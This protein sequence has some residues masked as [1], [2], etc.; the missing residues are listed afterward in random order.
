MPKLDVYANTQ[1]RVRKYS[2]EYFALAFT[3]LLGGCGQS[4]DSS[5]RT[6]QGEKKPPQPAAETVTIQRRGQSDPPPVDPVKLQEDALDAL[7]SGDLDTAFK[8]VRAAKSA[9]PDD[10]QTIFL[11]ARV[12]AERNRF[13]EAIKMLD[14]LAE[15]VPEARLPVLGQ[16]ADWSVFQGQWQ[17]AEERYRALLDQVDDASM[18]HRKLSQL[19]MREGRRL[20]ATAYLRELCRAGD[21]EELELRSLLITVHPFSGE[22]ATDELEPIGDMGH[23]RYEISQGNWDAALEVLDRSKS[24]GPAETALRGRIL[25]HLQDFESLERWVSDAPEAAQ[26]TADYWF[27]KGLYE[28]HRGDHQGGGGVFL[29]GGAS[30]SN[31]R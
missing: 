8:L 19:L 11:M 5:S 1:V 26:E 23:A 9:T 20:E 13:P 30:R 18:V 6:S 16:T 25:A 22:A 12:L 2:V 24:K 27:A 10:P 3:L 17:Q 4:V 21:I 28:A 31:R 7:D 14:E 29:L 15:A